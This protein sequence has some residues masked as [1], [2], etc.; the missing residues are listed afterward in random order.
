MTDAT[1]ATAKEFSSTDAESAVRPQDVSVLVE[2]VFEDLRQRRMNDARQRTE[3]LKQLVRN[4]APAN[5]SKV[6]GEESSIDTEESRSSEPR[7][8]DVDPQAT[9]VEKPAAKTFFDDE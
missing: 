5:P 7:R 1:A 8:L 9:A 6:V 3:W 4:R 2:Q